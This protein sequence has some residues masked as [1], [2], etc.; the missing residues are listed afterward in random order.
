MS[1]YKKLVHVV[2]KC[3]YYIEWVLKYPFRILSGEVSQRVEEDVRKLSEWVDYE[4]MEFN[5]RIDHVHWAVSV[6]QRV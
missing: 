4:V 5:V 3:Y 6:Q 2:Y 1:K